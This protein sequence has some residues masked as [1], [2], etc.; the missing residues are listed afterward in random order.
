VR[1]IAATNRDPQSAVEAG[2][3]RSDLFYRLA[4]F[5]I[6]MPP[7]R[8]RGDDIGLLAN[9]FLGQLNKEEGTEKIFSQSSRRL[10]CEYGWPGNVRE[11]KNAVQ[12]AFILADKE[13]DLAV[14]KAP[15]NPIIAGSPDNCVMLEIGS[16]LAEAEQKIIYATLGYC[17]GNKTRTAEM[18]GVSLKTL[19][20]RLNE[21]EGKLNSP[22]GMNGMSHDR[23]GDI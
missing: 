5:P 2:V 8:E 22:Q 20:N 1:V 4:V 11:L 19:Y 3:M 13:L 17:G 7:L 16:R 6:C 12:R 21:Y 14:G 10:M 23:E 18:L 15:S 9:L